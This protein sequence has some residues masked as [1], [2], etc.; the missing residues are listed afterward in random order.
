[1]KKMFLFVLFIGGAISIYADDYKD[2]QIVIGVGKAFSFEDDIFRT[3][4][5]I[6]VTPDYALNLE[7]DYNINSIW[8]FCI[9][10][11]G[12][13]QDEIPTKVTYTN[14]DTATVKLSL[15]SFNEGVK[16]KYYFMR[17]HFQPY[18][19][20]FLNFSNG[21]LKNPDRPEIKSEGVSLGGGTGILIQPFKHFGISADAI[22]SF[23]G[24]QWSDKIFSNTDDTGFNNGFYGF[25]VNLILL[26]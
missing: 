8:A 13:M 4:S 22:L 10:I 9:H 21:T 25:F 12:Y 2:N 16:G 11:Y 1:M 15:S 23:G 3:G 20:A 18:A 19:F 17:D 5:K 7:Y 26:W 14:G 24:S 6:S